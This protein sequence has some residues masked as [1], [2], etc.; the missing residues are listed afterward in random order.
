MKLREENE[1]YETSAKKK[2]YGLHELIINKANQT[3]DKTQVKYWLV[4]LV[5]LYSNS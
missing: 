1:S 2:S 4:F 5:S 3:Q